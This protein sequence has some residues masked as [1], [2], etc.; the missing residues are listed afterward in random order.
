MRSLGGMVLFMLTVMLLR[1][2]ALSSFAARDIVID[3]LAFATV[4]WSL[5]YGPAAGTTFGFLLGLAADLDATYWLGRHALILSVSGW[6]IG[7]LARRVVRESIGTQ[8]VL[9][10]L[11]TAL[12]QLWV[13]P[14]ELGGIDGLMT[15]WLYLLKRVAI[16]VAVT[17]PLGVIVLA[18]AKQLVGRPI[19]H[20]LGQPG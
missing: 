11:V 15:G 6:L 18:L 13:V 17:A 10:A 1:S 5:R 2:T 3:A 20:A 16:A 14:F 12:H 19:F 7:W 8:L 4:A 9:I